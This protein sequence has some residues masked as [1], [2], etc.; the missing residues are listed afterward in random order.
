MAGGRAARRDTEDRLRSHHVA[1]GLALASLLVAAA[2]RADA[3]NA[4]CSG[5]ILY[6]TQ[7]IRD[8]DK[9][10]K[11]SYERQMRKA[12]L[13]LEQC[14]TE[15]PADHEAMGYLAWA[16]AEVDSAALAG[17]AFTSAIAGLTAKGDKKKADLAAGNRHSYWVRAFN[18][19]IEHIRVAQQ[20]YPEFTKTP[21]DEAETTMKGEAEKHYRE[22]LADLTRASL[23]KPDDSQTIRNLGSVHAFMGEFKQAE[24]VFQQ[25]LKLAPG[26]S[27]L[28]LSLKAAR[29]SFARSL[30]G[31]KKYDEAIAF[32]NDM[33]KTEPSNPDHS[34]SLGE[35]YFERAQSKEGDAR[36]AEFRLAG[37]AYARGAELKPTDAD[38]PYNAALSYTNAGVWDKAEAMWR[39]AAKLRADDVEVLA[40]LGSVLAEQ[41]KFVE[42]IKTVHAAVKLKPQNKT[43]HRQLGSIYTKAGNNGKGTEE[44]MVYLAMQSGQPAPDAGAVAKAARAESAAGK[45]AASEGTP[46]QVITWTADKETYDTWFYWAKHRAYTFKLGTIVNKADWSAADLT[47]TAAGGK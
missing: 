13:E 26:D 4:H 16:Y 41:K 23:L 20:A 6:V 33:L 25:G 11:D 34:V 12:V 28:T 40:S 31:A 38:L 24:A 36:K 27:A 17:R 19:G 8:R 46:D 1:R 22:A 9:G 47:I 32:F 45:T 35:A 5:G 43:L 29:V 42:A 7:A 3:R 2:E 10:D 15:D 44:L 21:T 14:T 37:D 18:D 30:V 39:L